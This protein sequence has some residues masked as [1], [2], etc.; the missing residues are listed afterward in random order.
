MIAW[1]VSWYVM[2]IW[3]S[4]FAY[5]I[6]IGWEIFM[7]AG[8]STLI[9]ALLTVLYQSVRTVTANPVDSIKYE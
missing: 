2:D 3:L 5:R 6:N 7:A 8:I 4:D 1:P 9:I